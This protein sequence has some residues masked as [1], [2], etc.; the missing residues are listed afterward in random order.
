MSMAPSLKRGMASM[1]GAGSDKIYIAIFVLSRNL[2]LWLFL[3]PGRRPFFVKRAL[4]GHPCT[5]IFGAIHEIEF[6][7]SFWMPMCLLVY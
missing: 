6:R 5:N 3:V 2:L 7:H 1:S 4:R